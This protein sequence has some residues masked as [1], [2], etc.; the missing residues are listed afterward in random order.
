[1]HYAKRMGEK[2][3]RTNRGA[4]ATAAVGAPAQGLL[5][6]AEQIS[7][8]RPGYR[9]FDHLSF[10]VAAGTVHALLDVGSGGARDA[11]L[12]VAGRMRPTEGKLTVLGQ[13][14]PRGAARV[15][16]L[17]GMGLFPGLN[18]FPA[19]QTVGDALSHELALRG[20]ALPY[21]EQ[22]E[23]L[24]RWQLATHVDRTVAGL[25]PYELARLGAAC[26]AAGGVRLAVVPAIEGAVPPA[27]EEAFVALMRANA[28]RTGATFLA[29]TASPRAA[30]AADALTPTT[31]EAEELLAV[32][33]EAEAAAHGADA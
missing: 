7:Y 30:L 32:E 5:L 33:D 24:A 14:L 21:A 20:L 9:S 8:V 18:D 13:E 2:N 10:A 27:Q 22:L 6:K 15:R 19:H 3:V 12:A 16:R 11:L 26:A 29:A 28:A 1:M 23:H 4:A 31:I 17:V 25:E